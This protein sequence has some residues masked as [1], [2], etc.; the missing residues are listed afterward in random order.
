M[1]SGYYR[2][3]MSDSESDSGTES[4]SDSSLYSTDSEPDISG[5]PPPTQHP[6]FRAFAFGL[7]QSEM[8][9]PSFDLSGEIVYSKCPIGSP[10]VQSNEVSFK[11]YEIKPDTSGN[12]LK[13]STQSITSIVMLD[14][15]D[16][17]RVPFPQPTSLTLR[18]PRV[19][20]NVASFQII[21][22][23][24][25]SSF[26]YFRETKFNTDI[27]ILEYGRTN[28]GVAAII[29]KFIRTGT[30]NITT[31]MAELA[32]QLNYTPIFYDF[33]NGFQDFALRFASTGD[34]S[35]NFNYPGDNYYDSMANTFIANPTTPL[36]VSK[37][38][39]RQYAGLSS[40]TTDQIKIAYYY[41]VLKE[42]LLSTDISSVNLNITSS[43]SSLMPGETVLSRC[44]YTFQGIND[45]VILEVIN[46]NLTILD[47]Y[48]LNNTFR[49]ALV[50]EYAVTLE[51]ESNKITISSSSLNTSL[52]T[53]LNTKQAQYLSEQ[54]TANGLTQAQY[55][56][57]QNQNTLLL[58][59]I[60]DMFY[61]LQKYLAVYFGIAFN[62][63]DIS[64]LANPSF[65]IPIRDAIG[66][67]GIS[68]NYDTSV[69]ARG[70]PPI[71]TD[72]L[73]KYRVGAPAYW[74]RLATLPGPSI[75]H[76]I[77]L[78]TGNPAT[79]SNYPY[80]ISTDIQDRSHK[81]VD[82]SGHLTTNLLTRYTDIIVPLEPAQYT[83]FKFGS[84]VRQTLQIETL[85]RPTKYRYLAYNST[86][87]LKNAAL[88]DN[89]YNFI[90]NAQNAGMD[91][92][93]AITIKSIPGWGPSS[94]GVSYASSL[95]AWGT[96]TVTSFIGNSRTFFELQAPTP[97]DA[98][99]DNPYRYPLSV[100]LTNAIG[101]NFTTP[102]N[103]YVYH[104]RAAFMADVSSNGFESDYNYL[105]TFTTD[106]SSA[107]L[108]LN[109]YAG[110]KYYV[111]ARTQLTQ[112]PTQVY[113]VVPWFP[114]GS[115]YTT[116]TSS[117]VGFDPLADPT[118]PAALSNWNYAQVTDPAWIRLPTASNLIPPVTIDPLYNPITFSTTAIGYD[119]S[120]VSTD[121]TNYVGF[122]PNQPS[123]NV[124]PSAPIRI[125]PVNGYLFQAI[126]PYNPSTQS[127]FYSTSVNA[128]LT[129]N[130][131]SLYTPRTVTERQTSIVHW[132]SDT[133]LPNSVNQ[134]PMLSSFIA[135]IAPF[136]TSST[137]TPLGGYVYG[138]S[139]SAVQFGDGVIGI[140]FVPQ[141][142]VWDIQR[143]AFKSVYTTVDPTIDTNRAIKY[144]GV[145]LASDYP[146]YSY[147]FQLSSAIAVLSSTK[148]T[149][150]TGSNL[151][152][153]YDTV[154]GTFYE[155]QREAGSSSNHLYGYSQIRG[156][157]NPDSNAI[158]TLVAFDANRKVHPIQGIAGS[159]TPYPYYSFPSTSTKYLDGNA[160]P[161][162]RSIV[163]PYTKPVP[164][165]SRG[166][167]GGYDQTQSQYEQSMP[168]GTTM[169]PY[170]NTYPFISTATAMTAWA[171]LDVPPQDPIF[172]VSGHLMTLD[173]VFRVYSYELDTV[174]RTFKLEYEM[175]LDQV[176]PRGTGIYWL[177]AAANEFQYVFASYSA[178]D[179][180]LIFRIMTPATGVIAED[181]SYPSP[182]RFDQ[183]Q[184]TNM[185]FNNAGGFTMAVRQ[186]ATLI[187]YGQASADPAVTTRVT[188][189]ATGQDRFITRQG[190]KNTTGQF[191]VYPV[192]TGVIRQYVYV[193]P[194][195]SL[196]APNPNYAV[197]ATT[198]G[199]PTQV[200]VFA[201]SR[202]CTDPIVARQPYFDTLLFL[203]PTAP[204]N[205]FQVTSYTASANPAVTSNAIVTQSVFTFPAPASHLYQG[206][207]GSKWATVGPTI[208]GNRNTTV[209]APYTISQAWQIF[210]PTQR[211]V[212]TRIS[213]NFTFMQ[214]RKG[215]EY[216]EYPHTAITA[217][218]S[219]A[220]F[221]AD[222]SGRWGLER[223]SNLLVA[224]FAFSGQ[225]F[226][227][228]VLSVPM[229]PGGQYQVA[230]RNYSPT[231]KSQVLL[232]CSLNNRYDFGY[233]TLTDLSDEVVITGSQSNLF[234]P[235]YYI[236]LTAFNS[237]F[238][239]ASKT[240]GANIVQ[241]FNGSNFSNVTGFGDFYQRFTSLYATYN[242]QV[243]LVQ[244]INSNVNSNVN[245]FIQSDLQYILP[246]TA[247]TRQRYTDPLTFSILWKSALTPNYAAIEDAW[248]LGWNL[249]YAKADTHFATVQIA[250]SFFK[251]LDDYINLRLSP[252]YDMNRMDSGS[253]ENLYLT[254]DTT[255]STKAFHAKLLLAPFGSYAQTLISNPVSFSPLLG[256]MDRLSF[257][258][259]DATETQ[260][261]NSDC[262][263]NMVVQIV[264]KKEITEMPKMQL[265]YPIA[266]LL[267][268]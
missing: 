176:I 117:L 231:E 133:Y 199:T 153:G 40:Y 95:A 191:Y 42:I 221:D 45:P 237:N 123:S 216:P 147:Q 59:V 50:N 258:W 163:V 116:L 57:L 159:V 4:E 174:A 252:E 8:A 80:N 254:Q 156:Q 188:T 49:Y 155:F 143:A 263:W 170:L 77:N 218:N 173:T 68:S 121:L 182:F 29:K 185:T 94:F 75:G 3:Y 260:I 18:L 256:R 135:P 103:L 21:Q 25:L 178:P 67:V 11:S 168:I 162:G 74:P 78:E 63:Y 64:Y 39:N 79:S 209:D 100:S 119:V 253:K 44:I 107:A 41:P 250:P 193:D 53:L 134:A 129:S 187:A 28:A 60:N 197:R 72:I 126:S 62:T 17:D 38:F 22:V 138:G 230:I 149:T 234:S 266:S 268:S 118:T 23:K 201:L 189:T 122:V 84:P 219:Q 198:N 192:A 206:A 144:L 128:I 203:S 251:I 112:C 175:T 35:V 152:F 30:Y 86:A 87:N 6:D 261:D 202:Q 61:Y 104:D 88:F 245:A 90:E 7:S 24:L 124:Y 26:F 222:I 108:T 34:F 164:D 113:R 132:Y 167:P 172:D 267:Q 210:Y 208:Y 69:I 205:M 179:N 204:L 97:T 228:S 114:S 145:Y 257:Q 33:P 265:V 195:V 19:Y 9:G 239:F 142:G 194:T 214:D 183:V 238:V 244:A 1:A 240:F 111:M 213:K 56:A 47:T 83:V 27:S 242:A 43:V 127:Y 20:S 246:P 211:I 236:A 264:E 10:L 109:V 139:N 165:P 96:S 85:P 140:S 229:E 171:P 76:P 52:V 157:F 71:T 115:A 259:L 235:E 91:V 177:G 223:S 58:A 160:P 212:F 54:L 196:G 224:D 51:A 249:G 81:Y 148:I 65:T 262:E 92:R 186:G 233:V 146:S 217:Y 120:G 36:I 136:T 110:E 98:S 82:A 37:Y 169:V 243:Q 220:K 247:Q 70:T 89:S 141:Q 190:P 105:S 73:A 46:L 125:D 161:D 106:I 16:R 2:P 5:S 226:N 215:I 181:V 151:D 131:D 241:G 55:T 137:S 207:L 14:S 15:I 248:G 66:A 130:G 227:A 158:Y 166:P 48:R 101:S 13:S 184:L 225:V 180:R 93:P 102:M 32:I 31:L 12:Q 255:G 150:F 99:G 232:R 200:T 154:G